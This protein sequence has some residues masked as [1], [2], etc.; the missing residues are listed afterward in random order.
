MNPPPIPLVIQTGITVI[1]AQT[2]VQDASVWSLELESL[3]IQYFGAS[4]LSWTWDDMND[5]D[6]DATIELDEVLRASRNPPLDESL[7]SSF[8]EPNWRQTYAISR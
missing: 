2:S 6:R 4:C 8:L 1:N 3:Y 7:V 5:L